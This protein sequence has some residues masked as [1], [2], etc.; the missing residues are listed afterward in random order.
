MESLSKNNNDGNDKNKEIKKDL[1][2]KQQFWI[3]LKGIFSSTYGPARLLPEI[4]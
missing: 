2:A 3:T 1:S 4:S